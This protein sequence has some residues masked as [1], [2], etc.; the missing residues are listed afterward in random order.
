MRR[1]MCGV[2]LKDRK[3]GA[4]KITGFRTSLSVRRDRLQW[5]G[6]VERDDADWVKESSPDDY[7]ALSSLFVDI[8]LW[9]R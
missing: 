8:D 9:Y 3:Y 2:I 5:F 1:W 6:H 7:L 4:Y